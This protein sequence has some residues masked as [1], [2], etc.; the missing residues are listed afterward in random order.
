MVL[1]EVFNLLV[2]VVDLKIHLV[3][4]VHQ[5]IDGVILVLNLGLKAEAEVLQSAQAVAHLI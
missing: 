5:R 3:H 1:F 4:F 2:R